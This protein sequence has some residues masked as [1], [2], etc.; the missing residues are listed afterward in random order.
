MAKAEASGLLRRVEGLPIIIVF[1]LML[2]FFMVRAPLVFLA[3]NIYMTFLSTLPPLMVL[4]IG[5]TFV[6][7]AGE[8][9]LSYPC[10]IAF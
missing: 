6:I 1:G 5:L 2:V 8:I 7:A 10:I 4:A 9:D 3:P